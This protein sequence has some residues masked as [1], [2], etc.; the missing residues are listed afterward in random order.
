MQTGDVRTR[1]RRWGD[2]GPAVVLIPGAFE[3]ADS[4]EPLGR[5][6]ARTHRVYAIDL[7]G[8]GYSTSTPPYTVEQ[9][10]AQVI[11]FIRR[12]RLTGAR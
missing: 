2:A 10:T 4:F 1:Y 12:M 7:T 6:L 9:Y 5:T 3:T 11:D 8:L